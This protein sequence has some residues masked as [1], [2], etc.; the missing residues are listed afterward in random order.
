MG[1][2]MVLRCSYR[3]ANA[4]GDCV[5]LLLIGAMTSDEGLLRVPAAGRTPPLV[6]NGGV[7]QELQKLQT[8]RP[9]FLL[10]TVAPLYV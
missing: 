5:V 8:I 1:C 9:T 7:C 4:A 2:P 10:V 6:V 3:L